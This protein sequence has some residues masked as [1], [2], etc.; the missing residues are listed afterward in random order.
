MSLCPPL[1]DLPKAFCSLVRAWSSKSASFIENQHVRFL[2]NFTSKGHQSSHNITAATVW[3][4][5]NT[6]WWS[7]M[8]T[9]NHD[10][11][12]LAT[13]MEKA[14]DLDDKTAG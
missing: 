12:P 8:K 11:S 3:R 13:A 10:T 2:A 7:E 5:R 9:A 4:Q 1:K 6:D 14:T